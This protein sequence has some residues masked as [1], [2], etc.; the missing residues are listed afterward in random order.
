[1]HVYSVAYMYV[2][3]WNL[4]ICL[5]HLLRLCTLHEC[6]GRNLWLFDC[7]F[8]VRTARMTAYVSLIAVLILCANLAVLLNFNSVHCVTESMWISDSEFSIP[9]NIGLHG[10]LPC[11]YIHDINGC[12]EWKRKDENSRVAERLHLIRISPQKILCTHI[13][14]LIFFDVVNVIY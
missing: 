7:V 12:C 8:G 10:V 5:N 6:N 13:C 3:L 9:K 14:S 2:V 11:V 4:M 1:M